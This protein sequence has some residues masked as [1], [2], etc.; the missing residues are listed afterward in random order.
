MRLVILFQLI[1]FIVSFIIGKMQQLP[2]PASFVLSTSFVLTALYFWIKNKTTYSKFIFLALLFCFMGDVVLMD[3]LPGGKAIGMLFFGIAHILFITCFIKTIK[4]EKGQILN[5][6]AL[7]GAALFNLFIIS[8]WMIFIRTSQL[9]TIIITGSILYGLLVANI[10][11]FALVLYKT[12]KIYLLTAIGGASFLLS[13]GILAI[14][15][16]TTVPYYDLLVKITYYLALYGVIYSD[17][18][19]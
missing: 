8:I 16:A 10:A 12:N 4:L 5:K 14:G 19:L 9:G 13:D 17:N 7:P 2:I 1:I 6:A 3:I 15:Q 11:S 18:K